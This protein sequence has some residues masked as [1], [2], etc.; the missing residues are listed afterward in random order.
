MS[1]DKILHVTDAEF[2]DKV[3][4]APGPVLVD[5]WAEW[6]GPCKMIA[7]ILDEIAGEYEGRLTVAKLNIDDNPA[8]PQR[9]G[10]RGI[11]TLMVF[12]GGEVVAS[13]VGALTKSQLAAFLEGNM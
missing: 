3:L 10:V 7:P 8:T 9:Y 11:P 13:K 2:E 4:K 12:K 6:C 5:Y 1:S